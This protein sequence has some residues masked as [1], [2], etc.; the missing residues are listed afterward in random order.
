MN[1]DIVLPALGA[2]VTEAYVV[3]WLVPV[4]G[5]VDIGDPVVEVMTDKAN[6]EIDSPAAG[7]LAEHR[8]D[9]DDRVTI[10]QVIATVVTDEA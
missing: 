3:A 7:T 9:V 8:F 6:V 2:G 10:G 5:R 1:A 4:G